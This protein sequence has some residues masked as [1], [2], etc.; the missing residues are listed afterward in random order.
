VLLISP[1]IPAK[2]WGGTVRLG[3]IECNAGLLQVKE[4]KKASGGTQ[5]PDDL[6]VA[7]CGSGRL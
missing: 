4:G 3:Q 2:E 6:V 1:S 7:L 5:L